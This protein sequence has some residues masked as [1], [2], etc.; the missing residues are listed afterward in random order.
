M[1]RRRLLRAAFQFSDLLMMLA[2]FAAATVATGGGM[3]LRSLLAMRVS[4]G[5]F[6]VFLVLLLAW[7]AVF[8]AAGTYRRDRLE[9]WS[10][11]TGRALAAATVGAVAVFNGAILFHVRLV[12]PRF[13]L[14]FWL[15]TALLSTAS[16]IAARRLLARVR[17]GGRNLRNVLV[18]GTNLRAI[19]Y[20]EQME[21][22]PELGYRV[23]GF[24]DDDWSGLA[25]FQESGRRIVA[26][27]AGLLEFLRGQVVDEVVVALPM[28]SSYARCAKIIELCEEQGIMV[29]LLSDLFRLKRA[30]TSVEVFEERPVVTIWSGGA[31]DGWRVYLKRSL[32]IISSFTLLVLLSPLLLLVALLVKLT[33]PGP[34]VFVQQRVGYNK[35][36]IKVHKFRTMNVDAERRIDELAHLNEVSGPV[37]KIKDDP[38]ITRFG[39]F[40]RHTS[41]DEL[42]QLLDVLLGDMS[43]VGPR[44]LP[45]RDYQGFEQDWHRR[46]L[47]VRPGIT[48]LWQVAG[49]SSLP[50]ERWMELDMEYIDK[51]SLLLD[52]KI[53]ARTI[54][55]VLRGTGAA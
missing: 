34:V 54:P 14:L 40:L 50:F 8:R 12:T 30:K 41:I 15:I 17:L 53:L 20:A 19:D 46:R 26:T 48:C 25:A 9:P 1:V 45:L 11:E 23:I 51:W 5:N 55:A 27:P 13:T 36:R 3:P 35:R 47:S 28:G 49:R 16:R 24:V 18:V 33:S 37:F 52:L 32:D 10:V 21:A 42:P 38:R 6:A 29:R 22:R 7:H 31:M 44:P 4:I 2:A 43:L 39:R